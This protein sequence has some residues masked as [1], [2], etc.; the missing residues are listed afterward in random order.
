MLQNARFTDFTDSE[1]LWKNQQEKDG[2]PRL[3]LRH[4]ILE[5]TEI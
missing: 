4:R 1:L 3:R 5:N 2:K